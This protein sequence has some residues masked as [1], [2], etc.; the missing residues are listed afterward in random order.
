M[1]RDHT[2]DPWTHTRRGRA[3]KE[4]DGG[5]ADAH[6]TEER[7]LSPLPGKPHRQF[8]LH[9]AEDELTIRELRARY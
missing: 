3:R 8:E 1:H 7:E 9:D 2:Q 6:Q 4:W 5:S